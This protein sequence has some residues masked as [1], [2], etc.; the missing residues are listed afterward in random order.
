MNTP[1]LKLVGSRKHI[2][3]VTAEARHSFV[4][5]TEELQRAVDRS[6]VD[7]GLVVAFC[8][9]TTCSLILNEWELG[10]LADLVRRIKE[11]VPDDCYYEHDDLSVRTQNLTDDERRNGPAHVA[12][13]LMGGS[14]HSIPIEDGRPTLGRWQRLFLL[15]L[16]EPK[17]RAVRFHVYGF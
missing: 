16:D 12:Q 5:L 7:E 15:E 9:H 6:N 2:V 10:A 4:D 3:T 11:V 14:S 17:P 13:M 1:A 8:G